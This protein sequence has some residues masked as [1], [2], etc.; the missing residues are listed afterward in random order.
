MRKQI[1]KICDYVLKF[2]S[3]HSDTDSYLK[4]NIQRWGCG[5]GSVENDGK[6]T[7]YRHKKKPHYSTNSKFYLLC[8]SNKFRQSPKVSKTDIILH[9]ARS[10]KSIW[11]VSLES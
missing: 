9:I 3:Q 5:D 7:C 8:I 2:T 10:P 6:M 11:T 4:V 1:C